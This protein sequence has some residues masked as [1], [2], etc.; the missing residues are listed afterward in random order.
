M[1]SAPRRWTVLGSGLLCGV[2]AVIVIYTNPRAFRSPIAL[3]VL[4]AIGVLAAVLQVRLRRQASSAQ[5]L[6]LF[7]NLAGI[8]FALG[9]LGRNWFHIPVEAEPALALVAVS[10]FSV[11]TILLLES[12]RKRPGRAE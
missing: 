4:A 11:S 10:C 9:A 3:V 8:A 2:L 7:L 12:I 1:D 5:G 6:P